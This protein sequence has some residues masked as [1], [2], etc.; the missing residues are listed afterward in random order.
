[1]TF[2]TPDAMFA[3]LSGDNL[4]NYLAGE[5]A[6]RVEAAAKEDWPSRAHPE[7]IYATDDSAGRFSTVAGGDY[8]Q[9]TN[10]ADHGV[11]ANT[12]TTRL[13]P[14][15]AKPWYERGGEDYLDQTAR[16]VLETEP[17]ALLDHL[18]GGG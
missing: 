13:G 18:T 6:P 10:E 17:A 2:D 14:H 7:N 3:A 15:T 16:K 1:M 5:V 12:G 11:Y 4:P 8:V 9:V